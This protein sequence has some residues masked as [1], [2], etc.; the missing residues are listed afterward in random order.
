MAQ[1]A[2]RAYQ[3]KWALL[4]TDAATV[5]YWLPDWV[6]DQAPRTGLPPGHPAGGLGLK[7]PT[8]GLVTPVTA[9]IKPGWLM[10]DTEKVDRRAA[11]TKRRAGRKQENKAM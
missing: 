10:T 4:N 2:V 7:K 8:D 3:E 9:T 11:A 6:F 1:D 5:P